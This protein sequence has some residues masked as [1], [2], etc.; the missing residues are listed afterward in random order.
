MKRIRK[1]I[2]GLL[3]QKGPGGVT[4]WTNLMNYKQI[5]HVGTGAYP[6]FYYQDTID[7]AGVTTLQE[8]ALMPANIELHQSPIYII[9]GDLAPGD[10]NYPLNYGVEWVFL[11]TVP[12]DVDAWA[13]GGSMQGLILRTPSFLGYSRPANI[14]QL[15]ASDC[16]YGRIRYLQN[17]INTSARVSPVVSEEFFGSLGPTMADELYVTRI[18]GW[19]GTAPQGATLDQLWAPDIE[20]NIDAYLGDMSELSQIMELRR[21][22]LTQQTIA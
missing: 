11:T 9:A 22:Y 12:F 6:A 20:F 2:P 16:L 19:W 7:I 18:V 14:S 8:K 4:D 10:A 17:D 3:A 5:V 15:S 13:S 1:S 21:S